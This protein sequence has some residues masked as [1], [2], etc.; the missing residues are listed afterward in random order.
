MTFL[1]LQWAIN[2]LAIVVAVKAIDGIDFSGRWWQMLII[3][4][5]FGIINSLIKPF[6]RFLSYPII[7]LT[8]GIFTLII[9]AA[10]LFLT[11]LI[12]RFLDLGLAV[13]GFF[14]AVLGAFVVSVVSAMLSWLINPVSREK[15]N[16]RE[17]KRG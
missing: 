7:L 11:S 6:I 17:A 8:L 5:I 10:M 14:P 15:R 9:N 4:A 13:K 1:V 12:S 16:D 2:A 3:G